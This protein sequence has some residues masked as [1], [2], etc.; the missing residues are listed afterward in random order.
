MWEKRNP[1]F[2]VSSLSIHGMAVFWEAAKTSETYST[3]LG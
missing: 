3:F 1:K 2:G